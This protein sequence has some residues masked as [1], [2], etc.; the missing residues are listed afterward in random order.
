MPSDLT[1][2]PVENP[3]SQ[4]VDVEVVNGLAC[5]CAVIDH[6]SITLV[7]VPIAGEGSRHREEMS[8]QGLILRRSLRERGQVLSRDDQQVDGRLR[9]HVLE[10]HDRI[11]FM[12]NPS[13]RLAVD[14]P[15]KKAVLHKCPFQLILTMKV[16][17]A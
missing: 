17:E 12:N 16:S 5:P 15:A 7:E 1:W 6:G 3:A 14:D 8:E 4:H 10:S 11:V 13:G 9:I 2:R